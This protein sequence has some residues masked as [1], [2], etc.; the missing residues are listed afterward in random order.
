MIQTA[1]DRSVEL[2]CIDESAGRHVA[3]LNGLRV[4]GSLGV[5]LRAQRLGRSIPLRAALERM[6]AHGVWVS[7]RV[8]SAALALSICD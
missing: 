8:A 2:V 3:A 4:T 6:R 5:L 1:L 7:D